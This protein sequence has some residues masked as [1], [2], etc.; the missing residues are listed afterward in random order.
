MSPGAERKPVQYVSW[1]RWPELQ[2]KDLKFCS[3]GNEETLCGGVT[4][5]IFHSLFCLLGIDWTEKARMEAT[6]T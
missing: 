3:K 4:W 5:R 1:E 2:W 6:A